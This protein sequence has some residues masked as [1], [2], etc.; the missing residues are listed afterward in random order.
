MLNLWKW[1]AN[2]KGLEHPT[3]GSGTNPL[4]ILKGDCV[5]L[6][7]VVTQLTNALK[8]FFL[9]LFHFGY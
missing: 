8:F 3:G 9:F 5:R 6:L 4:R 1:R 2:R 7:E